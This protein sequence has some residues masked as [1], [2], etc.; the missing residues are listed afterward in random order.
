MYDKDFYL[1]GEVK[2]GFDT[3]EVREFICWIQ[4]IAQ[5]QNL[6]VEYEEGGCALFGR[7]EF[8]HAG[9]FTHRYLPQAH[10]PEFTEENSESYYDL[11]LSVLN[12]YGVVEKL[13]LETDSLKGV[14]NG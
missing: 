14:A 2:W 4:S 6:S 3:D 10:Y 12:E 7:Y 11:L 8:D 1:Y 13:T 9:N 5:I